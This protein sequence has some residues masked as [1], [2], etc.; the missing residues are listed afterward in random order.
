MFSETKEMKSFIKQL[1]KLSIMKMLNH[2]MMERK[3]DAAFFSSFLGFSII[4]SQP[5]VRQ[6]LTERSSKIIF[7]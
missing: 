6:S 4:Y 5:W 1:N 7:R 2:E 3:I